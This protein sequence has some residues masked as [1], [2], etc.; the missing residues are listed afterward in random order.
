MVPD[1]FFLVVQTKPYTMTDCTTFPTFD[2]KSTDTCVAT[3]FVD[4]T[5]SVNNGLMDLEPNRRKIAF[6]VQERMNV[7]T[8]TATNEYNTDCRT[9]YTANGIDVGASANLPACEF[10]RH[11]DFTGLGNTA[12]QTRGIP[13]QGLNK[14]YR[15]NAAGKYTY[16]N[17]TLMAQGRYNP[18]SRTWA[19]VTPDKF[20][21]MVPRQNDFA[22][23]NWLEIPAPVRGLAGHQTIPGG[24]HSS[25]YTREWVQDNM[26]NVEMCNQYGYMCGDHSSVTATNTATGEVPLTAR[27]AQLQQQTN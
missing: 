25:Y 27:Y 5:L 1:F 8:A 24:F 3:K 2:Q 11:P 23:T 19:P 18:Q 9:P 16:N 6:N 20:R 13:G 4:D 7:S 21:M 15:K 26:K 22:N 14:V 12:G 10:D 17:G